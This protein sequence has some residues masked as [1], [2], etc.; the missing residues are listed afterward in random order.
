MLRKMDWRARFIDRIARKRAIAIV[1]PSCL[2]VGIIWTSYACTERHSSQESSRGGITGPGTLISSKNETKRSNLGDEMLAFRVK[3]VNP[4]KGE[5]GT[6]SEK[7]VNALTCFMH[8]SF[9]DIGAPPR[10]ARSRRGPI[11]RG[12]QWSG[13]PLGFENRRG[14]KDER[15]RRLA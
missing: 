8:R 13:I 6:E 15:R 14:R 5:Y 12:R 9:G 3:K 4:Y 10:R 2:R 7:S 1:V 11:D